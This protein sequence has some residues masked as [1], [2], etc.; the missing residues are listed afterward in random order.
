[1]PISSTPYCASTGRVAK[2]IGTPQWLLKLAGLAWVLPCWLST[3]FRASLV[4]VLPT[5]PVMATIL[6]LLRARPASPRRFRAAM[7]SSTRRILSG[8]VM[9]VASSTMTADAP[10]SRAACANVWPSKFGPL[11][12]MNR[13]PLVT[14]RLSIEMPDTVQS[15]VVVP[16]VAVW[17]SCAVHKTALVIGLLSF[18]SGRYDQGAVTGIYGQLPP[19]RMLR[20]TDASSNGIT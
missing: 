19:A 7:V 11:R 16:P 4:P 3:Y 8:S 15:P 5:L 1:M 2:L 14:L 17:A 20:A 6:A 18:S 13:S 12:A 9:P 10:A